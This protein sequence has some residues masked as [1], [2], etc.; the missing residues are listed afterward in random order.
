VQLGD[1]G[2]AKSRRYAADG[3]CQASKMNDSDT[4]SVEFSVGVLNEEAAQFGEI[5]VKCQVY[6][7]LQ[8][9][10]MRLTLDILGML[11]ESWNRHSRRTTNVTVDDTWKIA[12]APVSAHG[13]KV[14]SGIGQSIFRVN[15][16]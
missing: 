16:L 6:A 1:H 2:I 4:Y 3:Q 5:L 10:G 13:R 12:F 7:D 9:G 8:I 15:R 11:L 14:F